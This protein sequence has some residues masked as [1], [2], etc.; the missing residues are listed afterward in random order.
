MET[1]HAWQATCRGPRTASLAGLLRFSAVRLAI[2]TRGA[3]GASDLIEEVRKNGATARERP[4][5]Y[6][7]RHVRTGD[8]RETGRHDR[9]DIAA[10]CR[11]ARDVD[12]RRPPD[13]AR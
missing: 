3:C 9:E 1:T 2:V 13:A 8:G 6:A 10:C 7:R 5:R 12:R 4:Y 11:C